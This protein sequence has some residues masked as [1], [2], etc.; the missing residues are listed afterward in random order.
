MDDGVKATEEW[1]KMG[2]PALKKLRFGLRLIKGP[3]PLRPPPMPLSR[4]RELFVLVDAM[5]LLYLTLDAD[6][7]RLPSSESDISIAH[8]R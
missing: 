8:M 7:P 2:P 5:I 3:A 6:G 4:T 1:V